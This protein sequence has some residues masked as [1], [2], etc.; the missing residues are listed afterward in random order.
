MEVIRHCKRLFPDAPLTAGN[1]AT[2]EGASDLIALGVD[3]IKVGIG[4]GSICTTRVVAGAGVPQV[5]AVIECSRA[6]EK[7]GI[8]IISDGGLK[9]SGDITKAIAAGA[10]CVMIGCL[11]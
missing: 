2:Y 1:M 10:H 8:P 3:A 6:A 9:L 4:P 7:F 11:S 5:S